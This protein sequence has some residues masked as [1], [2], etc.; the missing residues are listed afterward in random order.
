M[1]ITIL[2]N[3]LITKGQ[4]T[5]WRMTVTGRGFINIAWSAHGLVS[6]W[7]WILNLAE[8]WPFRSACWHFDNVTFSCW[9]LGHSVNKIFLCHPQLT[10]TFQLA[11]EHSIV[12][13]FCCCC[14]LGRTVKAFQNNFAFIIST[15]T[16]FWLKRVSCRSHFFRRFRK[17][18]LTP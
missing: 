16:C 6:C 4:V 17:A 2:L 12:S 13:G 7:T 8:E 11:F 5:K 1:P 14:F 18:F 9:D 3:V 10:H 15:E